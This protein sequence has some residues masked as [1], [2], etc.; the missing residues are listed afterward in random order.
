MTEFSLNI[1][2]NVV[3]K[4]GSLEH[5]ENSLACRDEDELK[6]LKHSML[7]IKDVLID[8]EEK[9]SNSPEL[10]LWLKQLNHVFYDAEDVLDEL[11]V[12]N[13][14]RQVIDRGNFYTRKVLRCFSS[15]NP[16]IFR[17][18]IGRKLK[19]I[20][21]GLDAIAAGNVKRQ[22]TER[23]EERRPLNRER[24][25]HSF[26]HSADI[27]G[28]DEDKEKIIQLLL[29]PSDEEDISVLPIAGIGGM[30]KTTLAKMA[31][32]DERVV[33][34]FQFKMWV[35]VSRDFDKKRL[36]EKLI[37]SATGGVGFD[38]SWNHRIKRLP[39]SICKL[40]NLQT[41]FLGGCD[42]IEE[43]PRGMRYMES[44]R[45][46]WLAT[47]QTSLPRDEIGCLKSLRFLWIATCEKLER[48]FE[49]MKNLSALR[50]LYI[51]TCPSLKS[52]P[53]SIK[54]LTSLQ[55]LHIS[56]CEAL[57]FH[58]QEACEFKL[59][60][61]VLCF[62]EAV[63]ELPEWLIRGSADTLKN[64]KLEFCPELH[65][66]PACL[67][68][69]SALQELRILGCPRLAERCDR[70]TGDDWEKIAHIPKVIVD[71]VDVIKQT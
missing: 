61:L 47:R 30:G 3:E 65:E 7:V 4:L 34:H 13:L 32:N 68:T 45:F 67:K 21:E 55:D 35:Y 36:M 26:V 20:N 29:H 37:I 63:Q 22:L 40:Q 64:L 18:T 69:F 71:N 42:E 16:L 14:R 8:A 6:K 56:G 10:R 44:L 66:L 28:R 60:K 53:R 24:G 27:I 59:K 38:L 51:V 58:N 1:A 57:N 43:L 48:L 41:L 9:R 54:Y 50:S 49:D 17:S 33:K 2:E 52:L 11:E 15:S 46:L 70:E 62:L 31:Y 39:N 12:E 25:T 23:A 5:E 19:R